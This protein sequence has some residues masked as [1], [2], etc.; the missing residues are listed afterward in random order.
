MGGQGWEF[1]RFQNSTVGSASLHPAQCL[2]ASAFGLTHAWW[3][4]TGPAEASG[5]PDCSPLTMHTYGGPSSPAPPA[6]WATGNSHQEHNTQGLPCP[7]PTPVL[8]H[9]RASPA[10]AAAPA[11]ELGFASALPRYS[12]P[13][14]PSHLHQGNQR[15]CAPKT[16]LSP[17]RRNDLRQLPSPQPKK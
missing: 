3:G 15:R 2:A 12:P 10:M 1:T 4:R 8:T 9:P 5:E 14:P 11:P 13:V 16:K 7:G 6:S 17:H